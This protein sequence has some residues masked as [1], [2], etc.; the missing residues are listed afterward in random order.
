MT[1]ELLYDE[2]C[3]N[4]AEARANL[5]RALIEV[6]LPPS[7]TERMP[8]APEAPY[9]LRGF[10]SPTVLVNGRDVG[11]AEPADAACCRVYEVAGRWSGA[12]PGELIGRNYWELAAE[13]VPDP[14]WVQ[15]G[16]Q[17]GVAVRGIASDDN[18]A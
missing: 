2:N 16:L 18:D 11:G 3:P 10:G 1:V 15:R 6:G 5:R 7:W 14:S 4:V 17:T 8:V 9:P 12:P 13:H